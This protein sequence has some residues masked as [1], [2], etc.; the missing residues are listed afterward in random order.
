M[1]F[2]IMKEMNKVPAQSESSRKKQISDGVIDSM[3]NDGRAKSLGEIGNRDPT[4]LSGL[5]NASLSQSSSSSSSSSSWPWTES[6]FSLVASLAFLCTGLLRA[7]TSPALLSIQNEGMLLSSL[8]PS[9][10]KYI[11]SWIASTPPLASFLGTI[12]SGPCLE[13]LGRQKTLLLLTFPSALGWILIGNASALWVLLLGRALT[14][15][16]SGLATATVPLYIT[17]LKTPPEIRGCLGLLPG[18]MLA[19][20]IL[21][22]FILAHQFQNWKTL[23]AVISLFSML[24]SG[25]SLTIPESPTWMEAQRIGKAE[26]EECGFD[27]EMEPV[28]VAPSRA[29]SMK[30]KKKMSEKTGLVPKE[31]S[32]F[33]TSSLSFPTC[34]CITLMLFQQFSGGNVIIYYLSEILTSNC[35][36]SDPNKENLIHKSSLIIGLVQFLGFFLALALINKIGRRTLLITSAVLM[37]LP[38]L[39]LGFHFHE[40]RRNE[41]EQ[42]N[43]L[44]LPSND[45]PKQDCDNGWLV[46]RVSSLCVLLSCYSIGLGPIP[47]LLIEILLPSENNKDIQENVGTQARSYVSCLSSLV[48]HLALFVIVKLFPYLFDMGSGTIHEKAGIFLGPDVTFWGFAI[49]CW[50]AAL[51][52][53]F[54]VPETKSHSANRFG[55]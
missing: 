52:T 31:S 46:L 14:G 25:L 7:Y 49:V 10:K 55:S 3:R 18:F 33:S 53:Y 24:L 41:N 4:F 47:F 11:I 38:H 36:A 9:S 32:S 51:F 42:F 39:V 44:S 16:S 17:E 21:L 30:N 48:N 12:L 2:G 37:S 35:L 54:L 50:A 5:S 34:I 28:A 20:G 45:L 22:G 23:A 19:A 40:I 29:T 1:I 8:S 26:M 27:L 15:L 13:R 43:L 6:Y